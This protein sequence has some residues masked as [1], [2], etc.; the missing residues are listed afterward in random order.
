MQATSMKR[1]V[2]GHSG[3][4]V[5]VLSILVAGA[6]GVLALTLGNSLQGNRDTVSAPAM[7][8]AHTSALQGEGLVDTTINAIGTTTITAFPGLGQGEGFVGPGAVIDPQL[9][10]SNSITAHWSFGQGE[11]LV[12]ATLRSHEVKPL[13]AYPYPEQGEGLVDPRN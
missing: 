7:P 2:I 13:L 3:T 12:D 10:T 6:V 9:L 11:G 8:L 1:F 5:V 4:A